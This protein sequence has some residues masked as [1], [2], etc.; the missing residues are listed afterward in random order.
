[1]IHELN[2]NFKDILTTGKIAASPP[3][4]DE[5]MNREHLDLPRLVFNFNHQNFGRLNEMIRTINHAL[6]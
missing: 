3:L 4:K 6:P 2:S 5:L 1:L